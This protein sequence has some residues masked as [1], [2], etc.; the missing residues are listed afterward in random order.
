[1][2]TVDLVFSFDTT[3]SMYPCL[4]QVRRSIAQT[5]PVLFKQ[6]PDLRMGI[7]THGDYCDEPDTITSLDLTNDQE[8][9]IDFVKTAP[10]THGG[11]AD[12]CYELVL[13][14]ARTFHWTSGRNKALVLIGD[15][16]PHKIGY[17]Y[18]GKVNDLDWENEAGLLLEA[19]IQIY[20]IQA[21]GRSGSNKFYRTLADMSGAPK[22][23]LPQFSDIVDILCALCYQ[24][25]DKLTQFEDTLRTRTKRP[26][27]HVERTLDI[28]AGRKVSKRTAEIG[29]RFQVLDVDTNCDIKSFVENNG[30]RF[31]KGRGFY[32]FTKPVLVQEYKEVVA[33]NNETGAILYGGKARTALGIPKGRAKTRPLPGSKYTGFVQST[34]VNRKLLAGTKFLYEVD[35]CEG[36]EI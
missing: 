22:L 29:S 20:P 23:A 26:S 10:S 9:I 12:E 7:I 14:H 31:K 2:N 16:C 36:L 19:G 24:R 1:M 8:E 33:Q 32:Q 25:A 13:N 28:L 34:S 11:D 30:L 5:V 21:L 4:T 15:A 27:Y 6:I 18:G 35:E 17:R 3:G